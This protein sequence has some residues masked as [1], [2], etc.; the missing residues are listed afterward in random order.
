M[1]LFNISARFSLHKDMLRQKYKTVF[2]LVFISFI[3]VSCGKKG[4]LY[5]STKDAQILNKQPDES[6]KPESIKEVKKDDV[7]EAG[8]TPADST[9]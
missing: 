9:K 6:L 4:P 3:G 2:L 8:N 1:S 5:L 7:T